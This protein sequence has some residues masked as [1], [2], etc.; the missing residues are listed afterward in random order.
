VGLLATMQAL[1][2]SVGEV[3]RDP[4][5]RAKPKVGPRLRTGFQ[6]SHLGRWGD[7]R[8]PSDLAV[9]EASGRRLG[10]VDRARA[11]GPEGPEPLGLSMARNSRRPRRHGFAGLTP[12]GRTKV[13]EALQLLEERRRLLSFWTITLPGWALRQLARLN[14]WPVF[15]NRLL[16]QLR[17]KLQ[18]RL[19]LAL[20]VGVVELQGERTQRE[21]WPCPHLHVVFQGRRHSRS[22]P[23]VGLKELDSMIESALMQ[24]SV[25]IEGDLSTAGNVQWVKKSVRGYLS[26]YLTKGSLDASVW[27]GGLW[28][29]LIPRQWW[30]WSQECRRMVE[31]CTVPLP[32][33]FLAWVWRQRDVLIGR[34]FIHLK[35]CEVPTE[36][37]STYQVSWLGID[38]LA[39][40]LAWWQDDEADRLLMARAEMGIFTVMGQTIYGRPKPRPP[41]RL[42][43]S[44]A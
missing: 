24:A 8:G 12:D 6:P 28:E 33:G 11:E 13:S 42:L 1:K 10:S 7:A 30:M 32:T 22:A 18:R 44:L 16:E 41:W 5:T 15:V 29:N 25:Q 39:L 4:L 14:T 20:F 23:A 37:P 2:A 35:R 43:L 31:S 38:N 27:E 34:K 36:A 19:G 3:E 26:K 9:L 17:R 21:G 40:M